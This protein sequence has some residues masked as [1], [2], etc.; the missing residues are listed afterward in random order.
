MMYVRGNRHDYNRWESLGNPGWSYESVLPYFKKSEDMRDPV[1]S[2]SPYHGKNGYL[3]VEPFQSI[4]ALAD[5]AFAAASEFGLINEDN[6]VNGFTQTGFTQTQGTLRDGLRCSTNK[7]FLR[8]AHNRRNLHIA[9]NSFVEKVLIDPITKQAHGVLFVRDG[10]EMEVYSSR[11]TI[12]CAGA[13]QSPQL[14]MLSGIGPSLH[15]VEHNIDVIQNSPGVGENLQGWFSLY[16][17]D[18]KIRYVEY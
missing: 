3:T 7:A 18:Y 10:K 1:L 11:E 14:L 15:L 13:I 17:Y 5:L 16:F 8:P 4:S 2:N 9:L 6:D 12:L